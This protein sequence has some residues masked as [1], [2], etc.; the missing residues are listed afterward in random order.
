M[1]YKI[2]TNGWYFNPKRKSMKWNG[3]GLKP[4]WFKEMLEV[5]L[6]PDSFFLPDTEKDKQVKLE[7]ERKIKEFEKNAHSHN[8]Y[9]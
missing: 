1:T 8:K 9:S 4:L 7:L 6:N 3:V 5:G 2:K